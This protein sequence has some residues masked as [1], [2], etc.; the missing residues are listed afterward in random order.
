MNVKRLL[1]ICY[2]LPEGFTTV[3]YLYPGED[4]WRDPHGGTF[5]PGEQTQLFNVA[6][7]HVH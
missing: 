6:A 1:V 3:A 7:G 4:A 2:D 5:S